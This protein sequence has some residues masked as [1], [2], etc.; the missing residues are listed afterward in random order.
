MFD[1]DGQL[2][3]GFGVGCQESVGCDIL[4]GMCRIRENQ[5]L[6]EQE[7]GVL[8]GGYCMC[9]DLRREIKEWGN[10]VLGLQGCELGR[11][12]CKGGGR[13]GRG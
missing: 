9:K 5:V 13:G 8:D 2:V 6:R 7:E 11:E 10:S 4:V 3:V 1:R 12:W